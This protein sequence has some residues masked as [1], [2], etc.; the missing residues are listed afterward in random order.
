[1]LTF[2]QEVP[3]LIPE[4]KDFFSGK[5]VD[6]VSPR[7][8]DYKTAIL[9]GNGLVY[10]FDEKTYNFNEYPAD[11]CMYLLGAD[12]RNGRFSILKTKDSV[13]LALQNKMYRIDADN[14]VYVNDDDVPSNLPLEI[15]PSANGE[16]STRY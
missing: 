9:H 1:M 10:T 4:L 2:L 12:I 6:K 7:Y 13:V 5:K 11:G 3:E 14:K 16:D 15:R 8:P